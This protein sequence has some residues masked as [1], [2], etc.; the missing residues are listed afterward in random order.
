MSKRHRDIET[1]DCDCCM[2]ICDCCVGFGFIEDEDD[3]FED[4]DLDDCD[5]PECDICT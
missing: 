5:D 1:C 2:E 4:D 3:D